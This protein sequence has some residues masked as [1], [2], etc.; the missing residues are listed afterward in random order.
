MRP[1]ANAYHG[2]GSLSIPLSKCIRLSAS[3]S[4]QAGLPQP[5]AANRVGPSHRQSASLHSHIQVRS[6]A[7]LEYMSQLTPKRPTRTLPADRILVRNIIPAQENPR[8]SMTTRAEIARI[9]SFPVPHPCA[10]CSPGVSRDPTMAA[11]LERPVRQRHAGLSRRDGHCPAPGPRP[12]PGR[13]L[14]H[15]GSQALQALTE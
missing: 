10:Q 5:R 6:P 7:R 12:P 8:S 1:D 13:G 4:F 3:R 11:S 15:W 9:R 14:C 2:P